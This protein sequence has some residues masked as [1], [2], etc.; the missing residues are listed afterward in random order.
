MSIKHSEGCLSSGLD[1]TGY[2]CDALDKWISLVRASKTKIH[3]PGTHE[4]M[5]PHGRA[6]A[7]PQPEVF[8]QIKGCSILS[9]PRETVR[10]KA[11]GICLMPR[12]VIHE[13]HVD[14]SKGDFLNL[15]VAHRRGFID[16]HLAVGDEKAMPDIIIAERMETTNSE[17][18]VSYLNDSIEAFRDG[19]PDAEVEVESCVTVYLCSFKRALA[20]GLPTKPVENS[21]IAAC[22]RLVLNN[23]ANPQLTVQLLAEWLNYSPDYLSHIFRVTTGT[24]L[25]EFI[26]ANRIDYARGLLKEGRLNVSEVGWAVGFS[27]PGYFAR[28]F[29]RYTGASPREFRAH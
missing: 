9:T 5:A 19:A 10:L 20:T 23:L 6:H 25:T 16:F 13:E 15:V 28:V 22:Q 4:P 2:V 27:D 17:K 26:N 24:R 21:G 7:H 29:K 3:I 18:M 8:I 1:L 14:Q 12:G 11:G